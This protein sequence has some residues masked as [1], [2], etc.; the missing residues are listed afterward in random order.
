MSKTSTCGA[1]IYNSLY[2]WLARILPK[3]AK[4]Q[5]EFWQGY[6]QSHGKKIMRSREGKDRKKE[7]AESTHTNKANDQNM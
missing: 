2:K 3:L 5:Q 4:T 1:M 7:K 6:Q